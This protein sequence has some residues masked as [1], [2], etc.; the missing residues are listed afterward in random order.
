MVQL[1]TCTTGFRKTI[2]LRIQKAV[3]IDLQTVAGNYLIEQLAPRRYALYAHLQPGSLRLRVGDHVR[4]GQ[5]LALLGNS[6]NSDAPH[7]HFHI[8]DANSPL[9][10]EGVPYVFDRVSQLGEL[11]SL[12]ILTNGT[13]WTPRDRQVVER[14]MEIPV[15]NSVI[16]F[17]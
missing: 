3:P 16:R 13:G 8:C 5:Q 6:G 15:Q 4:T 9:G 12:A 1:P 14:K 11:P 2:R 7:L 17:R 10:C